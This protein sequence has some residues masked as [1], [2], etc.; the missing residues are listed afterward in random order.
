MSQLWLV[1][2]ASLVSLVAAY[3]A[4]WLAGKPRLIVFSPNST[5]FDLDPV[6][7]GAQR[8]AIRA[9]QVIV[10]NAGR[11]SA[12]RLQMIAQPGP[13]PWGYNIVPNVDHVVRSGARGEWLLEVAYLGPGETLTVQILNGPNIDSVRAQEGPAKLVP[14]IHQRVFPKWFNGLALIFMLIG[15]GT[16]IYAIGWLAITAT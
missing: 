12:T 9:G 11:K 1:I 16:T 8:L 14:V 2:L 15:F 4:Y 10:Q 7:K 13:K 3:F 5:A 6:E